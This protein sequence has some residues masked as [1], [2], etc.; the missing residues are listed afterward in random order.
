MLDIVG[1][2]SIFIV[3]IVTYYFSRKWKEISLILL[4]G[5][6]IR[7]T[8]LLLGNFVLNLPDSTADAES[9]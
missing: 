5:L 7:L 9:L 3:I 2:S 6:L 1:F 4:I 8:V